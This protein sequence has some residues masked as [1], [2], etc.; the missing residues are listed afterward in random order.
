VLP[1]IDL[2]NES[3]FA[4]HEVDDIGANGL[5]PN[6]LESAKPSVAQ[7]EPQLRFSIGCLMAKPPLYANLLSIRAA[8]C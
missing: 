8:W 5:L 1:S 2:D 7:R 6:E 4:A 3:F